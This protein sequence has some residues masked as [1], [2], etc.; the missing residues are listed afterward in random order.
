MSVPSKRIFLFK[1]LDI[2]SKP[3]N[4]PRERNSNLKTLLVLP[5]LHLQVELTF[6]SKEMA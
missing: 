5:G 2:E 1:V 3:Y 4:K 6:S